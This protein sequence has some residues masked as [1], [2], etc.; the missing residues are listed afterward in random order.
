MSSPTGR[1]SYSLR[2]FT[3][4]SPSSWTCSS[5][6]SA[7][8]AAQDADRMLDEMFAGGLPA[9]LRELI[10]ERAEGNPFFVEEL[11][12]VLIDRGLLTRE[13]GGGGGDRRVFWT[14]PVYELVE[15]RPD[16]RVLEDRDFVRR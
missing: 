2:T 12:G 15:A 7:A 1:Q 11:L 5:T 4:Q 3:G 13:D 9:E 14:G 6:C 16:L 8:P 10:V